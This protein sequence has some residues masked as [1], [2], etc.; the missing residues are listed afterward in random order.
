MSECAYTGSS[1]PE[2]YSREVTDALARTDFG[3]LKKIA[4]LL[5]DAKQRGANIYTAGNGGSAATASHI[6]ND[7]LKGCRRGNIE[8]LRASCLNDSSTLVTCLAND[9]CYAD[10]YTVLLRTYAR[11]GDVLLVFSGSGNSANILSVCKTA[12]SMGISVVGFGG[13]DGGAMKELC[14]ICL[15]APLNCM[16][17]IEDLHM[18]YCHSLVSCVRGLLEDI[19]DVEVVNHDPHGNFKYAFFNFD[20]T[21]AYAEKD[22]NGEYSSAELAAG[23]AGYLRE[24]NARGVRCYLFDSVDPS[25]LA[26][27]LGIDDCFARIGDSTLLEQMISEENIDVGKFVIVSDDADNIFAAKQ[28]GGYAVAVAGMRPAKGNRI[29]SERRAAV[30]DA[31]ADC[32]I[33]GFAGAQRLTELLF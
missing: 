3:T 30:A 10:I 14:D 20:G 32:I 2:L 11:R 27:R 7:L 1:D 29:D 4:A 24:L 6:V 26:H 17:Q 23:A 5:A 31:G 25:A 21:V 19:W 12:R 28:C 15:L 22:D 18:L 33:P 8:G 9:F 16:E 13:R